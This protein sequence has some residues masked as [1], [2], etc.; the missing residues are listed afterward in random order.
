M[1]LQIVLTILDKVGVLPYLR[2]LA[3]SA[4]TL[5]LSVLKKIS[6]SRSLSFPFLLNRFHTKTSFGVNGRTSLNPKIC[7]IHS[8]N[9]SMW[10]QYRKPWRK[11]WSTVL[12]SLAKQLGQCLDPADNL[13]IWAAYFVFP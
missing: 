5:Q 13:D 7:D 8:Y 1:V 3:I 2:D 6:F 10:G 11:V 9:F 12:L 4:C